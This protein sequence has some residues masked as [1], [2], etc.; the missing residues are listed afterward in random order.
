MKTESG[1]TMKEEVEGLNRALK[2]MFHMI[3]T[4]RNDHLKA[5]GTTRGLLCLSCG[6][7]DVNFPPPNRYVRIL[8]CS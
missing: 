6:S 4:L 5:I 3:K 1:K 8:F 7:K 2:R